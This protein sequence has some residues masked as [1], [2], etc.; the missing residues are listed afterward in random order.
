VIIPRGQTVAR[1]LS[2]HDGQSSATVTGSYVLYNAAGTSVA[3]GT[4]T[5]GAV[6]VMVP[7]DLALGSGAW[8]EWSL[9][10]PTTTTIRQAVYVS[11]SLD[12][13]FNLCSTL[14]LQAV[15]PWLAQGYPVGQSDWES[16]CTSATIEVLRLLVSVTEWSSPTAM[17]IWDASALT[18]PAIKRAMGIIYRDAH[19]LTG[20][21]HLL[22]E[23]RALDAEYDAWW[24]RV[25]LAWGDST[26][27]GPDTLPGTMGRSTAPAP[28]PAAGR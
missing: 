22:E 4:V 23:A 7:S 27:A 17:D 18:A 8:E 12:S 14:L 13:R 19:A 1:S 11:R 3:T 15:R 5:T 2:V 28:G 26:G 16:A 21:P 6:S 9:S 10:A 24:Q 20:A 25:P